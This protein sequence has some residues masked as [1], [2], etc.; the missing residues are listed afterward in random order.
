MKW[1]RVSHVCDLVLTAF[2]LVHIAS[3]VSLVRY[4]RTPR[5]IPLH[6]LARIPTVRTCTWRGLTTRHR[7][8]SHEL[9]V[10]TNLL[11][12]RIHSVFLCPDSLRHTYLAPE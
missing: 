6:F 11:R 10:C 5:P 4:C 12:P 3:L 8:P 7:F 1:P 9:S 2:I